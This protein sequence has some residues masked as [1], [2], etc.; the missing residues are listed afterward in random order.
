MRRRRRIADRKP[1]KS[2][3]KKGVNRGQKKGKKTKNFIKGGVEILYKSAIA[4]ILI[5]IVA[6]FLKLNIETAP[7]GP[8]ARALKKC[9]QKKGKM[10]VKEPLYSEDAR[11]RFG[12]G[13]VFGKWRQT[14][15]ARKLFKT[16]QTGSF[17]SIEWR[18]HVTQASHEWRDLSPE[19]ME[20]W[21]D[22]ALTITRTD[23][24]GQEYHCT[25]FNEFLGLWILAKD[26]GEVPVEDA[27]ETEPP[28]V[29][30]GL[31]VIGAAV[32]PCYLGFHWDTPT[33]GKWVE[34]FISKEQKIGSTF[35]EGELVI[36]YWVLGSLGMKITVLLDCQSVYSWK[37]RQVRANGQGGP[38]I[39]GWRQAGEPIP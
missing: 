14:N 3:S 17:R 15:W 31:F 22:Y 39:E 21:D 1:A 34:I 27:P 38:F 6:L 20:G 7:E 26:M 32:P 28:P 30:A 10:R 8:R 24:F 16:P 37:I 29:L 13:V 36:H 4:G 2:V 35:R 23:V 11:G 25:G 12:S 33:V 19:Q 9:Q 5:L 18:N